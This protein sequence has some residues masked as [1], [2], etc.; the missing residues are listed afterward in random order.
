VAQLLTAR[1]LGLGATLTTWH[2]ALERD[3]KRMLGIPRGVKTFAIVPVGW[4][5]GRLGPVRRRPVEDVIHWQR[6]EELP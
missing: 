5:L 3:F 6:W 4:P 2:L 1:A